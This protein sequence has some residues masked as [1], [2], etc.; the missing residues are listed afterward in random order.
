VLC[1]RGGQKQG[2]GRAS[3]A[4]YAPKE[5]HTPEAERAQGAARGWRGGHTLIELA[6]AL[7]IIAI[8]LSL[9]APRLGT[10][11]DR[12]SVRSAATEVAAILS[13]AR[14][15]A[16]LRSSSAMVVIDEGRSVASIIAG[17]DTVLSHDMGSELG[18][19]LTATRDTVLYGPS[20]RGWGA[21][22]TSIVVTRGRWADTLFVSR[23]GRVRR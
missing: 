19:T 9:A 3:R 14:R 22:N 1:P 15:A 4:A 11:R 13:S 7:T 20:G 12:A 8:L 16:M 5:P 21:S 2:A 17:A 18:V 10:L 23:L 6:I